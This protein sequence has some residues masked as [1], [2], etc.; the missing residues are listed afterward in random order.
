M[1]PRRAHSPFFFPPFSPDLFL[2]GAIESIC[3]VYGIVDKDDF[4]RFLT[5]RLVTAESTIF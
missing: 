3:F 2:T 4:G 5:H 1:A